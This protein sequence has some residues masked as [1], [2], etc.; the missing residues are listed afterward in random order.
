MSIQSWFQIVFSNNIGLPTSLHNRPQEEPK[1]HSWWNDFVD[2][3]RKHVKTPKN[4]E[5]RAHTKHDSSQWHRNTE[6]EITARLGKRTI[7]VMLLKY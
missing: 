1:S 7:L 6:Y 4:V 2:Q 5:S 3:K